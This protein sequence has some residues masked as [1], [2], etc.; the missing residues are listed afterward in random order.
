MKEKIF[1]AHV[2]V[3]P[4]AIA[5]RARVALGKFYNF[6]VPG[7]ATFDGYIEECRENETTG[8]LV[9]SVAT[10]AHQVKSINDFIA[11]RASDARA[12]GFE[13]VG[14][15]AMHQEFDAV[16]EE[17]D[18]CVGMGLK[19]IKI[20]PDIQGFD[21]LDKRMY[22]ICEAAEGRLIINFHMGDDREEYRF[23][24]PKKLAKLLKDF[25]K[26]QVIA[27]HL[28]GYQAWDEARECLYGK[29]NVWYDN[30]SALWAMSP[31]RAKEL[32]LACGVDRV[33]FGT[34]FPVMKI[35]DY[36]ELFNKE[37]LDEPVRRAVLYENAK[38]LFRL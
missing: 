3:Y 7:A 14:F 18:R 4:E 13:T 21:L 33:M 1:D 27:S 24:E 16:E 32:T 17:L 34:D 20:H 36:L 10:T 25:P 15:A 9:F 23:S 37:E 35:K 11:A 30:S 38:R 2:H 26:L 19:G 31:E 8:F 22:R 12:L 5:D 28:G 6:P 29:E